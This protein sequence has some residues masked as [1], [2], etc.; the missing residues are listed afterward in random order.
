MKIN[1]S[2]YVG[3]CDGVKRAYEMVESLDMERVKRPVYILG[4]LVHNE[5]VNGKI[6]KKGIKKI[7]RDF[8]F[9]SLP[10]E[11]RTLIITAHG[12]GPSI[13]KEAE[14]KNI[15]VIDTTCPK[16]IKAQRLAQIYFKRNYKIVIVGDKGHK[17]I[18]G[19]NDWGGNEGIIVSDKKDFKKLKFSQE[20]KIIV[21][22][23][24]TQNE[25]FFNTT[26]EYIKKFWPAAKIIST[27][28]YSTHD[29]QKEI[30]KLALE[31]DCVIVIGS[32]LSANSKRL[33]EISSQINPKTYFI[34]NADSLDKELFRNCQKIA[35][36]AGASAPGWIIEDVIEKLKKIEK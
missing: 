14:K 12:T 31:N 32:S 25:N 16:V 30:R 21:L 4:S 27:I 28:C 36:V 17:E 5:E 3:F 6:I 10:G 23:Q 8:F 29:R 19:I 33:F 11:I 24:T 7:D 18:L 22:S 34:E 9:E 1:L 13:Y 2:Q 35:I 26:S 20:D 15:I